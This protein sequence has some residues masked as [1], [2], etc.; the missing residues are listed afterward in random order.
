MKDLFGFTHSLTSLFLR[1]FLLKKLRI[2]YVIFTHF[3][4][5]LIFKE[6]LFEKATDYLRFTHFTYKLIFDA[7]RQERKRR[8]KSVLHLDY[9]QIFQMFSD[10]PIFD[11]YIWCPRIWSVYLVRIF[12]HWSILK[13]FLFKGNFFEN[14]CHQWWSSPSVVE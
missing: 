3:T 2:P 10:V 14:K 4:Y 6:I 13:G 5:K 8:S 12:G 9:C 7:R 1:K 11:P